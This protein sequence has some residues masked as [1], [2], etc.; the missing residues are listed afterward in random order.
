[1]YCGATIACARAAHNV[2]P[3]LRGPAAWT[4]TLLVAVTGCAGP[5][6]APLEITTWELARAEP[7]KVVPLARARISF[8]LPLPP[9]LIEELSPEFTLLVVRQQAA[10]EAL[11]RS[12]GLTTDPAPDL[13]AGAIVGLVAWVG[14]SAE[15]GWPVRLTGVRALAGMAWIDAEFASG[16]YYPLQTAG[17]LDL[18]YVPGLI[19]VG[20]VRVNH[21]VFVTNPAVPAEPAIRSQTRLPVPS[22]DGN[23]SW[24]LRLETGRH[25]SPQCW[26]EATTRR[27]WC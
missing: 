7:L 18:C 17:Y 12:I 8:D 16:L 27:D 25:I 3:P 1:M 2:P 14:E 26:L 6:A 24:L 20:V 15:T 22:Q 11:R 5:A 21:R 23:P 9:G 4:G 13:S 19:S 10:W